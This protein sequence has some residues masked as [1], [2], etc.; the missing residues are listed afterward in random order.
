MSSFFDYVSGGSSSG[1]TK[2][3]IEVQPIG[4]YSASDIEL[5]KE[6]GKAIAKPLKRERVKRVT[7]EET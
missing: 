7:E 6:K 4:Y 2:V 1:S 3:A 5:G